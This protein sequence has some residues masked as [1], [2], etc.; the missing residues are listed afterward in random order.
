M[1]DLIATNFPQN[2]S[3]S[4]VVCTGLIDHEMVYCIRKINWKR[5]PERIRTVRNYAKYDAA[6]F[7]KDCDTV[8][9]NTLDA[10]CLSVNELWLW[11]KSLFT[12]IADKHAPLMNK[13]VRTNHPCA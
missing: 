7:C 10:S 2:I 4:G 8:F 1:L 9:N 3:L 13:K 6:K 5:S 12:E 11:F